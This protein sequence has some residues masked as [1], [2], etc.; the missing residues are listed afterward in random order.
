MYKFSKNTYFILL[1]VSLF[2]IG[3]KISLL[4][5]NGLGSK[6]EIFNSTLI[7]M[8]LIISSIVFFTKLM[9]TK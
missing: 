3:A 7:L 1:A 9:N 4:V 2:G 8:S 5:T 6:E